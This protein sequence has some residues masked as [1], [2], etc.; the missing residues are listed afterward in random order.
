MRFLSKIFIANK[1]LCW[2]YHNSNSEI[3]ILG[4]FIKK[5]S[6]DYFSWNTLTI[7]LIFVASKASDLL[8]KTIIFHMTPYGPKVFTQGFSDRG[9]GGGGG[10][11]NEKW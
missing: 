4:Y 2:E 10:G 3:F 9:G 11:A 1:I 5:N 7:T 8:F 6:I